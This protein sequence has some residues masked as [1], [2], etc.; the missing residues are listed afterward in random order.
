FLGDPRADK[1]DRLIDSL[2]RRPE[3]ADHWALKWSDLLRNEEKALDR[4]GVRAFHAWVRQAMVDGRP[5]NE[6]AR[7]LIAGR[8]STYSQPAANYCRAL[9]APPPPAEATAQVFLGVRVQC[10]KCHNPPFDRWTQTDYHS[11]AAFFAR[12][13]YRIIENNRRDKL[14]KHE[15]VGEQ[16]V[17]QKRD[18]EYRHPATGEVL[19]PR[20][21]GAPTP[22]L[23]ADA[24]RLRLLADWVARPDNPFFARAQANRIWYHLIGKGIV[25]PLDDFRA[26]NP[27][28]NA[29]LL[30]AL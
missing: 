25:D 18:G 26:S 12:I 14:D 19:P 24:D 1:R 27:P 9:R 22:A 16:V 29:A 5:L 23:A 4:R 11:L 20:F 30:D 2:L 13:D 7:E 28:G 21:L 10:A 3:F 15:F 17:Y 8:G 6:F